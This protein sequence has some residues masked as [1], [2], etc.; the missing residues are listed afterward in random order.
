MQGHE[1]PDS[2]FCGGLIG[3]IKNNAK[4]DTWKKSSFLI[5]WLKML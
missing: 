2:A 3:F 5:V 4:T 1:S